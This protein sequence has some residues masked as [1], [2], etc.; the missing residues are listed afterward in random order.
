ME[1]KSVFKLE[2]NF[3]SHKSFIKV[4]VKILFKFLATAAQ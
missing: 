2:T 4:R 1:K 3:I